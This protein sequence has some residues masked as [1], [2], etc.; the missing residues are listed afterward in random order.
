MKLSKL[1]LARNYAAHTEFNCALEAALTPS[2]FGDH[3]TKSDIE[4]YIKKRL[5]HA[6]EIMYG[7][8][9]SNFTI[10][11][12]MNYFETGECVPFTTSQQNY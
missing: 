11:Q 1:Q 5:K 4:R 10:W 7:W 8:H 6:N 2:I 3:M 9:D 12:R